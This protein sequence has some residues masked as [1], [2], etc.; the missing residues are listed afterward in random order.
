[1]D[2]LESPI[3]GEIILIR[4][5]EK[6]EL[7]PDLTEPE[8][9]LTEK[10]KK[11]ALNLGKLLKER[12]LS[13]SIRFFVSPRFRCIQ[14]AEYISKG[15][16]ILEPIITHSKLL[17]SPGPFVIDHEIGGK[18]FN[19]FSLTEVV[20]NYIDGYLQ[21]CFTPLD[22]GCQSLFDFMAI[23]S[24]SKYIS[25][26]ISHDAIII[27]FIFWYSKINL[28]QNWLPPLGGLKITNKSSEIML[29]TLEE[30]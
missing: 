3:N 27:P 17:G 5:A 9:T 13:K 26:H 6:I 12:G 22:V 8:L 14:T 10:G 1:M 2:K 29:E 11:D 21:G 30:I 16:E 4:H 18:V 28:V 7:T 24:S 23:Q 25:I 19:N 15:A 20:S